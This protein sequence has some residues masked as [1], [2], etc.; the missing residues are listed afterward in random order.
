M[1][2]L[3]VPELGWLGGFGNRIHIYCT[4]RKYAE[5]NDAKLLTPPWMGEA[6]FDL[7][8]D[9]SNGPVPDQRFDWHLPASFSGN[10]AL[11][12]FAAFQHLL[13]YSR[14]DLRRYLPIKAVHFAGVFQPEISVHYRNFT[15]DGGMPD[16]GRPQIDLGELRRA[17][18]DAGLRQSR[19]DLVMQSQPEKSTP[20]DRNID[21]SFIGDFIRLATAMHVFAYPYST[22]SGYAAWLNPNKVYLP[23]GY[24]PGKSRCSWKLAQSDA[25][26]YLPNSWK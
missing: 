10:A 22:F 14:A 1:N 17:V 18:S 15:L 26:F 20:E 25:D 4:A 5:M 9:R 23:H 16:L 11:T 8:R 7:P 21:L 6:V 13:I 2:T 3:Q 24:A 19:A 12:G